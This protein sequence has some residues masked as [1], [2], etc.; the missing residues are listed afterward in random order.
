MVSGPSSLMGCRGLTSCCCRSL[1]I[2]QP[3]RPGCSL[4]VDLSLKLVLKMWD[5]KG[6]KERSSTWLPR[7][8]KLA[9]S[10]RVQRNSVA[11]VEHGVLNDVH[12]TIWIFVKVVGPAE[13]WQERRQ[14]FMAE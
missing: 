10:A 9:S 8:V 5:R 11:R 2:A 7:Q 1:G 13:Q 3:R 12:L 14:Y 6:R 4:S